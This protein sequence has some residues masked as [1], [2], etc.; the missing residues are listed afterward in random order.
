[1]TW[2]V[3]RGSGLAAFVFLAAATVWGLLV[4][5]GYVQRLVKA[6]PLT[7]AHESLAV[8]S[9]L[10]TAAHLVALALDEFV[11]FGPRELFIPGTAGYRPLWVSFGVV[12]FYGLVV[13]SGSFYVRKHLG[14]KAWRAIHYSTFG[15]F[16]AA[17]IHGIMSGTD[18][19]NPYVS[20]M[21][22]LSSSVV[23]GLTALRIA[24]GG[25]KRARRASRAAA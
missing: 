17:A 3:I 12:A 5:G 13:A 2:L 22:V 16:A 20:W 10:A 11:A 19:S 14:Q 6:K 25:A 4:S 15:L 8:A 1:M 21:Y 24:A 9:I 18:S 7:Y 23:V